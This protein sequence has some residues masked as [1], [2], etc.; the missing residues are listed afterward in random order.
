MFRLRYLVRFWIC[1]FLRINQSGEYNRVLNISGLHKNLNKIFHDR[2]LTVLWICLWFWICQGFKYA[3]LHMILKEFSVIDIWQGLEYASSSEY[4]SVTQGS[5]G[6]GP[7]YSS[8]SQF[9]RAW[10]R[11]RCENVKVTQSSV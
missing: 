6:N 5:I 10:I 4:A 1:L 2:C 7:S 11:I 3:R 9:A 8:G